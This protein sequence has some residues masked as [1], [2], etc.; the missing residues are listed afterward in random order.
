M[1]QLQKRLL[2]QL[3]GRKEKDGNLSNVK[4]NLVSRIFKLA[5]IW[6]ISVYMNNSLMEENFPASNNQL[7]KCWDTL[8]KNRPFLLQITASHRSVRY[9]THQLP[10]LHLKL[11]FHVL[12]MGLNCKQ[13][14]LGA[15]GSRTCFHIENYELHYILW[16]K[17]PLIKLWKSDIWYG[18][19]DFRC[20]FG[21]VKS[22]VV[23]VSE[24]ETFSN[25]FR[26][27]EVFC[28]C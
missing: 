18:Y 22:Q 11:F 6:L 8:T 23:W 16:L 7:Q 26:D 17:F 21:N 4:L 25:V 28:W 27:C 5:Q 1:I 15:K 3:R 12:S 14:W 9:N 2:L 19:M 24:T 13:L 20:L 10:P